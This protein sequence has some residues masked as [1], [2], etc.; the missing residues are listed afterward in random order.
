MRGNSD[1]GGWDEEI[2]ATATLLL[3]VGQYQKKLGMCKKIGS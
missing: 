3:A 1:F 2:G